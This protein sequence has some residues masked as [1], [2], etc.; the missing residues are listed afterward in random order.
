[1]TQAPVL[2]MSFTY[3]VQTVNGD[4]LEGSSHHGI[5]FQH[6]IEVVNRQRVESTVSLCSHA[7]CPPTPR[8]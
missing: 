1:M 3:A 4:G 2:S 8:Q 6:L 5:F 7:G